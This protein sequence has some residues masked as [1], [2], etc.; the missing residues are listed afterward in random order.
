MKARLDLDT[1]LQA[2]TEGSI[3]NNRDGI[4][5]FDEITSFKDVLPVKKQ[6]IEIVEIIMKN[7]LIPCFQNFALAIRMFLIL[8][9]TVTSQDTRSIERNPGKGCPRA[10]MSREDLHLSIIAKRNRDA[11]VSQLSRRL[12]ADTETRTSRVTASKRLHERGLFAS[13]CVPLTSTNRRVRLAS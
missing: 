3:V 6:P 4:Q 10:T 2:Q 8:P 7:D 11:T 9:V 5:L 12:Y 1:K 13:V